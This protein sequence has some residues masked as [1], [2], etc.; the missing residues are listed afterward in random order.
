MMPVVVYAIDA[1]DVLVADRSCKPFRVPMETLT[2]ARARVKDDKFRLITFDPP[3][4]SKPIPAIRP[5]G[6]HT[7]DMMIL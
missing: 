6:F 3:Q 5:L 4:T 1:D 7:L 2:K